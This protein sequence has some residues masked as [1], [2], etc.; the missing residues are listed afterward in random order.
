VLSKQGQTSSGQFAK[1]AILPR[2]VSGAWGRN[3]S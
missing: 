1:V 2:L 3:V